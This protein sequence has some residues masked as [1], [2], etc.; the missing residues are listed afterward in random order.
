MYNLY[1]TDV[2]LSDRKNEFFSSNGNITL[3]QK[4]CIFDS[5]NENTKK[6]KCNCDVQKN[7]TKIDISTI[8]FSK[9]VIITSFLIKFK[10]QI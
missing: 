10:I 6:A 5:Y 8:D 1:W 7:N 4:D 9:N 3:C 2:T